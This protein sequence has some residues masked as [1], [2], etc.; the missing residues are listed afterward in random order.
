MLEGLR[1]NQDKHVCLWEGGFSG[2]NYFGGESMSPSILVGASLCPCFTDVIVWIIMIMMK[3]V[4]RKL[5][6]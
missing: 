4:F 1:T 5:T 6:F 2:R 3:L